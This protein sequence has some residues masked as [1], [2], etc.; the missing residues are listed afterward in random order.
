MLKDVPVRLGRLE[1]AVQDRD[2]PQVSWEAH[3]LQ[4]AFLTVGATDLAAA[5]HELVTL[6]ERGDDRAIESVHRPIRNQWEQLAAEATRHLEMLGP[7]NEKP[8]G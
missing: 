8:T 4:G 3:G 5:C 1:K 2:G 6:G 7:V